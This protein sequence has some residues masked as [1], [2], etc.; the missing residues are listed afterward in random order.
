MN[1]LRAWIL[2]RLD[3]EEA[4]VLAAVTQASG[5]T[6]RGTD[7]L[8]AMDARGA[9]VGTVGGGYAEHMAIEAA[10]EL[11]E[12]KNEASGAP[13]LARDL[14]F[15]LSPES[16]NTDMVCGGRLSVHLEKI[17][18]GSIAAAILRA[19]FERVERGK[20]C[21][22]VALHTPEG[23]R[24]FALADVE[25][26]SFFE[27]SA[28]AESMGVVQTSWPLS[29]VPV[30]KDAL[31]ATLEVKHP[32][33]GEAAEFRLEA[34]ND[35]AL[36]DSRVF[37]LG[38]TPAPVVY[39]FGAGHVGKAT[40]DLASF[41][42]FRVVVT[43]DR[44]A[45][46]TVERFPQASLLRLIESFEHPLASCGKTAAIEIGPQDCALILSRMH[47]IDRMM[48]AH[49]L[50]TDAGYIGLI[51]SKTKRDGIYASLRAEGFSDADLARVHA[52]IGL[53]IGART[54]EEIAVS[55]MAEIIAVRAGVSTG[56]P[57][58]R[59]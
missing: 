38:F 16:N 55:I 29:E 42:G 41:V 35:P 47:D 58:A 7:A 17:E 20:A 13:R 3:R 36:K 40:C 6:A 46:L 59:V 14:D 53:A 4:V 11:F 9:M 12:Q 37:W 28:Q 44:P 1:Q 34:E 25:K 56:K 49:I 5:S 57:Y 45:L 54:P 15:D 32:A 21:A 50:R 52:P 27:E 2:Q 23:Q 18:P 24:L 22:F 30:L 39:I 10:R 43:D 51:G 33:F 8:L 48:L 26:L 31:V 19:C